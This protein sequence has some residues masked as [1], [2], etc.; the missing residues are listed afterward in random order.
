MKYNLNNNIIDEPQLRS[1]FF[2]LAKSTFEIDLEPWYQRGCWNHRYIPYA[3]TDGKQIIANVS[4]NQ[5]DFLTDGQAKK[6]VQIGTVMTHPNYR[7]Q[8]LSTFLLNQVIEKYEYQSDFIY[9]YANES[10]L[11]FYPKFGFTKTEELHYTAEITPD[12][13]NRLTFTPLNMD[14]PDHFKLVQNYAA[15]R[16]PVTA[17]GPVQSEGLVMFYCLNVFPQH[18]YYIEE[19]DA[20]IIYETNESQID[21]YDYLSPN[22]PEWEQVLTALIGASTKQAVFH[23]TPNST[24]LKLNVSTNQESNLYVRVQPGNPLPTFLKHPIT[25]IA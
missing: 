12:N 17:F 24:T 4:V 1:S 2:Q 14:H 3:L 16:K 5:F 10:V 6:A 20:V 13:T 15:R 19:L 22:K 21:L 18:I 7:N 25:S 11:S 8:G 23:F 9:L